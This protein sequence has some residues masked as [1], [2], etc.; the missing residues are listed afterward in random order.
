MERVA[1]GDLHVEIDR[2]FPLEEATA[3]HAYAASRKAFG[4]IVLKPAHT[5]GLR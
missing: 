1:S 4:R 2:V 5:E 3:A